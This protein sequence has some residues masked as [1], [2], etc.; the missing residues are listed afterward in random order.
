MSRTLFLHLVCALCVNA[1][2]H[3]F[4]VDGG[5]K[6]N[7]NSLETVLKNG[8]ALNASLAALRPGDTLVIP[9]KKFYLM[10]GI[11][12]QDLEHVQIRID[13]TLEFG[14]S[15]NR[16]YINAWPRGNKKSKKHVHE[17]MQFI[18][19]KNVTFSSATEGTIDG[20]GSKWWG[21]PGIGYLLRE[22]NRPRL[23]HIKDSS[24]IVVERLFLKDSP[25]WTFL[26]DNITDLVVRY[27]RV[28]ARRTKADGHDAIDLT[29]F[30]TDG[31]DF[32][33]CTN[34]H[35]HDSSVWN[36]D[37]CF[38]VKDGTS[39]VLIERVNASGVGLT[40]GSIASTVR[41]IT[42]RNAY[43]HHTMKGIYLKFRGAGLVQDVT[44]ENI[45]MDQPE[46]WAIWIGPAQQCDGCSVTELC[47]TKG[48]PCSICWPTVPGTHCNAPKNA[49]Y[50]RIT[51]RNITINSPKKS[52]GVLIADV[53]TP[54][55]NVVFDNVVVNNPA[56]KP[57][58][59]DGYLCENVDGV[60]TGS[61]SPVPPCFKDLTDKLEVKSVESMVV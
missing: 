38:D 20:S 26:G 61:T 3:D 49:Q 48:G 47:S 34:V 57:W 23:M 44:Y 17:C 43:M 55:K 29:A 54:M 53:G 25:Y 1:R 4:E 39:N 2:F 50:D 36:Q 18:N 13:G 42:F 30:N 15:N 9:S 7:D 32:A 8:A 40:I 41:N 12:A 33:R 35:V 52:A 37:D 16:K 60:A 45:V 6:A 59:K 22:E 31:F 5:A 56:E 24:D 10:G 58:G 46:Q 14:S 21:F 11:V 19:L 27:S 28:E 51:L